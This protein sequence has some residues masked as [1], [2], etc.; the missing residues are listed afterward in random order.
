[1]RDIKEKKDSKERITTEKEITRDRDNRDNRDNRD[2]QKSWTLTL[3]NPLSSHAPRVG[4]FSK[5]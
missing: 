1:M 5:S 3:T 2:T 4:F